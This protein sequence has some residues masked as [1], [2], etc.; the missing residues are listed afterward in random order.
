MSE[1]PTARKYPRVGLGAESAHLFR[2][3][4]GSDR[5]CRCRFREWSP[6]WAPAGRSW[7]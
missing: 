5:S 7:K 2:G 3:V 6:C 1:E 4:A